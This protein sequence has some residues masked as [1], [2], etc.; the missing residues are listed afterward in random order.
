[1]GEAEGACDRLQAKPIQAKPSQAKESLLETHYTPETLA[2]ALMPMNLSRFAGSNA[3]V[4][5]QL[6]AKAEA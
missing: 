5:L 3:A 4:C 1:M 6:Q 2:N